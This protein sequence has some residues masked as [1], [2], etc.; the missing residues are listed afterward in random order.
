MAEVTV[1]NDF[2]AQEK[3]IYHCFPFFP[4]CHEVMGSDATIF[5]FLML[6]FKPAFSLPSCSEGI[7]ILTGGR[8]PAW[9]PACGQWWGQTWAHAPPPPELTLHTLCCARAAAPL[10]ITASRA[11]WSTT[12]L[13]APWDLS[14]RM[15][16]FWPWTARGSLHQTDTCRDVDMA[17]LSSSP[18]PSAVTSRLPLGFFSLR[19]SGWDKRLWCQTAWAC[20]PALPLTLGYSASL[21]FP[22]FNVNWG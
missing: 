3:K 1:P 7:I 11:G 13:G 9:G 16:A 19:S 14:V 22:F 4:I 18:Y 10:L 5:M 6:S 15:S 2:G 12:V 17:G 8:V 21:C 20:I